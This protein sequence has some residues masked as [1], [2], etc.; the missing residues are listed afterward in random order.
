MSY[1]FLWNYKTP[2]KR[3]VALMKFLATT[4]D[5]LYGFSISFYCEWP[6]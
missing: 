3:Y 5:Q 6:N 4:Q 2:T 1:E